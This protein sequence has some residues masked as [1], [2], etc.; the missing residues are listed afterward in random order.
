DAA[1]DRTSGWTGGDGA[2]STALGGERVLWMFGDTFVSSVRNG[3]RVDAHLINNSAAIQTGREPSDA[4]LAFFYRTLTDGGPAAFLQPADGTGWIWPY[5]GVRTAEGLFLFLLQIVP[6]DGP[7]AFGF[8]PVSTWLGKVSNPEEPPERWSVS[9]QKIPWGHARRLFGSSVLLQKGYCYIYG[10]VDVEAGGVTARHMIVAR[11]PAEELGDFNAWRFFAGGDW[12][13]EADRAGRVCENVAS[14][15]SV[16]YQPVPGRYV[17]VYT[18]G[19]LSANIVLRFS[20]RPEGPWGEPTRV[21][22]CPEVGR[23]PRIF[24]YAAKGHPELAGAPEELIV[25]Y[26]ANAT[27]FALL[28]SDA[29]LY[30]PRFLRV[31]FSQKPLFD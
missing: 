5:H 18:E 20:P 7:A 12:V 1:F 31:T 26:M 21:Y 13:A 27:D 2:Y 23:D 30:R 14:E 17:L 11:V 19:G 4:A 24:C 22:R 15:F 10:T 25:T 29:R 9:Q 28:E 6:A 3:R 16:S 8:K